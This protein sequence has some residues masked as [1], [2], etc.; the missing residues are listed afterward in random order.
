MKW[1][2]LNEVKKHKKVAPFDTYIQYFEIMSSFVKI[3]YFVKIKVLFKK[4]YI[5]NI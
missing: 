4:N 3:Q 1:E 2:N 5:K